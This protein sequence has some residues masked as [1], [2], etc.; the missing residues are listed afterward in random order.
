MI[1]EIE[2]LKSNIDA[3]LESMNYAINRYGLDFVLDEILRH[4]TEK[5]S[6]VDLKNF[7]SGLN[8]GLNSFTVGEIGIGD[9]IAELQR[10]LIRRK[11]QI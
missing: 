4:A 6:D 5:L 1:L 10:L 2:V 11:T 8:G 3:T 9:Q 7:V